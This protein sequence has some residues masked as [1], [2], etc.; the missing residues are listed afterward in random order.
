MSNKSLLLIVQC[1]YGQNSKKYGGNIHQ[2][3]KLIFN[4]KQG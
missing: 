4:K 2:T 3:Q 1:Y